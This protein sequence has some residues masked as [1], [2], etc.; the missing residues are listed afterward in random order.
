MRHIYRSVPLLICLTVLFASGAGAF[1]LFMKNQDS[2]ENLGEILSVLEDMKR[3]G[4]IEKYA[5][6][7]AFAAILHYEPI[8][9]INLD[10]F[11]FC[12]KKMTARF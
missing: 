12:E 1:K 7:G 2:T 8:A 3:A 11:F 6:G 9:T 5:I 10:V 4:I